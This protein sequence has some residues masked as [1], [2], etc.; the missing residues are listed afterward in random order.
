MIHYKIEGSS[1]LHEANV[2]FDTDNNEIGKRIL[3]L[4]YGDTSAP[5]TLEFVKEED[6]VYIFK[7]TWANNHVYQTPEKKVFRRKRRWKENSRIHRRWI[8]KKQY[9][10]TRR[11][12]ER[13]YTK[14]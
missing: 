14:S 11:Y 10:K 7:K 4:I 9:H 5:C 12:V 6:G 3:E 1:E 13:K 8:G 2:Q